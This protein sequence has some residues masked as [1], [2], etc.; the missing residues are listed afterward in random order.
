MAEDLYRIGAFAKRTGITPECLRAWERRYGLEPAERA[1]KTRFYSEAQVERLS[2]IK[3]LI[4]QGHPVS[5]LIHLPDAELR[6][7]LHSAAVAPRPDAVGGRVGLV[8]APLIQARRDAAET[9][10]Q[11]VGEWA[12]ISELQAERQALP[13]V[14]CVIAYVP[15]LDPERIDL[16]DNIFPAAH[17][18]VAFKYATA[19]DLAHFRGQ[20]TPLHRWPTDWAALERLATAGLSA[21]RRHNRQFSD[22][23]LLHIGLM[24]SRADCACPRH[25]ADLVANLNDYAAHATRCAPGE[26]NHAAIAEEVHAARARLEDALAVLVQRHGLLATAN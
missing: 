1:G 13:Q 26:E 7:R 22:E 4:D 20:G 8:G 16:V 2:A 24:A 17:L 18:L 25:L 3:G 15:T 6:R 12:S 19:A 21:R 14:D 11:V 10:L 23:Q 9:T 5:A